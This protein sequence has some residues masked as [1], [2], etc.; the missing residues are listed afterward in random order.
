M[1]AAMRRF[2][3]LL[4]VIGLVAVA[5]C[6]GD[7]DTGG[8]ASAGTDAAPGSTAD[9]SSDD[10]PAEI[11]CDA[12]ADPH[13]VLVDSAQILA[14]MVSNS[15]FELV[16]EGAVDVDFADI[17][18]A[19]SALR[20]LDD[21]ENPLGSVDESLDRLDRV[22]ELAGVAIAD[23]DPE[24]TEAFAEIQPLIADG[25]SFLGAIGPVNYAYGEACA[26]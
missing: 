9:G 12:L 2:R 18:A 4:L 17:R 13:F 15:Q 25:A 24:S 16:A 1:L 11:D 26:S 23:P 5:A 6:S 20:P 10:A 7:D 22:A 19:I 21:V 3:A 8:D 14:S